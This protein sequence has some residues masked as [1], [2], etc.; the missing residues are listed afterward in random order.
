MRKA[1]VDAGHSLKP[2]YQP[3]GLCDQRL[4][5]FGY[6]TESIQMILLPMFLNKYT[7]H[8]L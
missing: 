3:S 1:H 8:S 2:K 7:Y 5:L 6:T 4:S